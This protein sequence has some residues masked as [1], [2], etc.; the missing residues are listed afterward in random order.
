[1]TVCAA[2]VAGDSAPGSP[3]CCGLKNGDSDGLYG[4]MLRRPGFGYFESISY[5][6]NDLISGYDNTVYVRVIQDDWPDSSFEYCTGYVNI[7][8]GVPTIEQSATASLIVDEDSACPPENEVHL[9]AI[10]PEGH[11]LSWSIIS[12]PGTGAVSFVGGVDTGNSVA[13]CYDPDD[14]Q[15]DSDSFQV[16]VADVAGDT[17]T[18]TVDVTI[19]PLTAPVIVSAQSVKENAFEEEFGVDMKLVGSAN[20]L[21]VEPRADGPTRMVFTFNEDVNITGAVVTL[22]VAWGSYTPT[23]DGVVA[24]GTDGME[25]QASGI[26]TADLYTYCLKVDISGV[27]SMA[28]GLTMDPVRYLIMPLLGDVNNDNWTDSADI[29]LAK[30]QSGEY[31]WGTTGADFRRDFNLDGWVDSADITIAQGASGNSCYCDE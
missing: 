2:E 17:D 12:S 16:E 13:I 21:L 1:V 10:D 24:V 20:P 3:E 9:T 29:N 6:A 15:T 4:L 23:L 22:S 11:A 28:S 25:V 19:D 26:V 8:N 5:D 14:G 31:V 30:E 18:I 27:T 7:T